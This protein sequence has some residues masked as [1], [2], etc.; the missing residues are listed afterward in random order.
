MANSTE[1]I[2]LSSFPS[3]FILPLFFTTK[4]QNT[5]IHAFYALLIW[6][7][8]FVFL[9]RFFVNKNVE[10]TNKFPSRNVLIVTN[11]IVRHMYQFS[12]LA[13]N[14]C[15]IPVAPDRVSK[16]I[17]LLLTLDV[18]QSFYQILSCF[19]IFQC[20]IV[21]LHHVFLRKKLLEWKHYVSGTIR[22]C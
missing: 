3:F 13:G 16:R 18:L 1:T 15:Q 21:I 22:V 14:I 7:I 8:T 11:F 12:I 10:Y 20:R 5:L 4:F 6:K 19:F 2:V 17:L 9:K